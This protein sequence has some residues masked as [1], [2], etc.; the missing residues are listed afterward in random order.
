MSERPKAGMELAGDYVDRRSTPT[1]QP[2]SREAQ[3]CAGKKTLNFFFAFPLL[4]GKLAKQS[5]RFVKQ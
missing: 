2:R 3:N 5:L 4:S 1:T